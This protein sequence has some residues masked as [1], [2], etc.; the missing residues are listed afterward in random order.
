M[1]ARRHAE[2]A[3][4]L[5]HML[6]RLHAVSQR[7]DAA[8]DGLEVVHA[9]TA[10]FTAHA[11]RRVAWDDDEDVDEEEEE[12]AYLA[13]PEAPTPYRMLAG[14]PSGACTPKLACF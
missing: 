7:A 11:H 1:E 2:E 10:S 6:R 12:E 8:H 14:A 13:R 3:E 5:D 4:E 9:S